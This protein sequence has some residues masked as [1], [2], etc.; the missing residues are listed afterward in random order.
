MI[1]RTHEYATQARRPGP[2]APLETTEFTLASSALS[3]SLRDTQRQLSALS[4]SVGPV[5]SS[6]FLDGTADLSRA[7]T[8]LADDLQCL[9]T[10]L[11]AA[12]EV[13]HR[14]LCY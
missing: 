12:E 14:L 11:A 5:P 4:Q 7:M 6:S 13:G 9:S 2:P 8:G 3:A 10:R 1:S